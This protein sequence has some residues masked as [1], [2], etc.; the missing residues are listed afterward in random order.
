MLWVRCRWT[1]QQPD[2]E[3]TWSQQSCHRE[4]LLSCRG[5]LDDDLPVPDFE[6]LHPITCSTVCVRSTC[7][8]IHYYYFLYID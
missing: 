3:W 1:C 8:V 5:I 2:H 6:N 4:E 7:I